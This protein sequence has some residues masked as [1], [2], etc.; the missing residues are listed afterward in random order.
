MKNT[1]R[2]EKYAYIKDWAKTWSIGQLRQ[3]RP[4]TFTELVGQAGSIFRHWGEV[5]FVVEF[6]KI[7]ARYRNQAFHPNKPKKTI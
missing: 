4:V 5:I 3:D 2:E 6:R 1:E 7:S